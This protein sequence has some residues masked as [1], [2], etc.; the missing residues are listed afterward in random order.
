MRVGISALRLQDGQVIS[1]PSSGATVIVGPNNSGKSQLLR[2]IN[3][4][5]YNGA[6]YSSNNPRWL[7]GVDHTRE[8]ADGEFDAW[9]TE[10]ARRVPYGYPGAGQ[11]ELLVNQGDWGNAV[12][13]DNASQQW[14]GPGLAVL[15]KWLVT[16]LPADGRSQLLQAVGARDPLVPTDGPIHRLWDDRALEERLS[17]LTERAFGFKISINRYAQQLQLLMGRPT[18]PDEPLPPSQKLLA[19]YADL[20]PVMSQGDGVRSLVALLLHAMCSGTSLTLIDEPEAFLHPP[21][22]RQLGRHLVDETDPD[23]QVIIATHSAD[24]LEGVL[25]G[26]SDREVTVLRLA[27]EPD[28]TRSMKP[29]VPD[30]IRTLWTDPLLRYS[31]FF[32]GVF[33]QGTLF[34][35]PTLIVA[36]TRRL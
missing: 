7:V 30:R 16:S 31:N 23:G 33:H 4:A 27:I 24:V 22:A 9:F 21:Q 25:E 2:E 13:Q 18:L 10:R 6:P 35:K 12:L 5:L 3:E 11:L 32:A 8:A 14:S 15:T 20:S 34:A 28:G 1:L 36:S 19:A 29:L 17:K 26:K